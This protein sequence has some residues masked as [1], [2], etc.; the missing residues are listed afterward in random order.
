MLSTRSTALG[1]LC[2]AA[3]A[4]SATRACAQEPV[5]SRPLVA[6]D[7][8]NGIDAWREQRLDR[9]STEYRVVEMGGD[10]VL[11]ASSSNAAA[12]LLLPIEAGL[13]SPVTIRWRWRV[14]GSLTDNSEETEKDG[15][16]YAARV[17][18][19]FG[20]A[21]FNSDTRALAYAWAGQQPVGSLYPNPYVPEVTTIVLRSGDRDAGKWVTEQRDIAA[22]YE[23]A[24]GEP[25]PP[26]A[27]IALL[28][29]TDDTEAQAVTWFDDVELFTTA[30][31]TVPSA[32]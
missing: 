32:P 8:S 26:V 29:D 18:V 28:V 3:A 5:S 10:A 31:K 22:D 17:F 2:A 21:E 24:F 19:I 23:R 12:A 6:E 7:F 14:G 20:D 13:S 30:S 25:P 16:D 1:A 27:A 4:L 11:Q 15:D 9:R